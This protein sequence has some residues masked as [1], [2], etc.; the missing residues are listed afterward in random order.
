MIYLERNV[1]KR[2]EMPDAQKWNQK[3]TTPCLTCICLETDNQPRIK[4]KLGEGNVMRRRKVEQPISRVE[5]IPL[6]HGQP[7]AMALLMS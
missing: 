7:A 5:K 6:E 1:Y 3:Q 4:R 2:R